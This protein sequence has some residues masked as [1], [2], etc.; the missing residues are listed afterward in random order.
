MAAHDPAARVV[1]LG[2]DIL[3]GDVLGASFVLRRVA[4]RFPPA[5]HLGL[6]LEGGER[7]PRSLVVACQDGVLVGPDNGILMPAA[8]DLGILGAYAVSTSRFGL[9]TPSNTLLAVETYATLAA[10]LSRGLPPEAVGPSV[11]DW[12][13]PDLPACQVTDDGVEGRVLFVE[14]HGAVITNVTA[15]EV[16]R[17][18]SYGDLLEVE[19]GGRIRPARLAKGASGPREDL[20][21]TLDGSNLLQ[22]EAREGSAARILGVQGHEALRIRFPSPRPLVPSPS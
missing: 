13:E 19:V 15:R 7:A 4:A 9:S 6:V 21:A 20:V 16:G 18:A 3:P 1:V 14:A 22:L 17:L 8:R 2:G 10:Q 11:A 12:V 5:V